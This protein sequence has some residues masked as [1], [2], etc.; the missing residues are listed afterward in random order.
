MTTPSRLQWF[1]QTLA[2][3]IFWYGTTN[4]FVVFLFCF[5][6][7]HLWIIKRNSRTFRGSLSASIVSHWFKVG[8]EFSEVFHW[9]YYMPLITIKIDSDWKTRP[10][11]GWN[12][13]LYT[14]CNVNVLRV[15]NC[16]IEMLFKS[17]QMEKNMT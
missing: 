8:P 1:P 10:L 16:L 4:I 12:Y 15:C 11:H 5:F 2:T 6:L 9:L 17:S 7:A 3:T 13:F 14:E